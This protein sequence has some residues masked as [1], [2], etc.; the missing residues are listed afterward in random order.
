MGSV[1]TGMEVGQDSSFGEASGTAVP[2]RAFGPDGCAHWERAE[3]V[4]GAVEQNYAGGV[5]VLDP[6]CRITS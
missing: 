4:N 5:W 1:S 2:V 3:A 6:C